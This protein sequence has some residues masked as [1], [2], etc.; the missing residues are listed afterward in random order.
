MLLWTSIKCMLPRFLHYTDI[1]YKH[2][3]YKNILL[4]LMCNLSIISF[5]QAQKPWEK[6]LSKVKK[7]KK[8]Y[9]TACKSEK[10]ALHQESNARADS[11]VSPD[12]VSHCI[13]N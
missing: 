1:E 11:A 5:K 9:H 12:H 7:A 10:S 6:K 2:F 13:L 8:E 3:E 4:L